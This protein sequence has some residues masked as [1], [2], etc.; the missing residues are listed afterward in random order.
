VVDGSYLSLGYGRGMT[1][2][3]MVAWT[4]N[5]ASSET[6]SL[7]STEVDVTPGTVDDEYTTS[8]TTDA[9]GDVVFDSTRLLDPGT[10]YSYTIPLDTDIG[11]VWAYAQSTSMVEHDAYGKF[12][13]NFPSTGGCKLMSAT[14]GQYIHGSIMWFCWTILSLVQL[15]TNRYM[16]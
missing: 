6:M 13:V 7:W 11:M 10:T 1:E 15:T 2:V 9:N 16:I 14:T 12:Y 4:G 3:N 5:G 8:F